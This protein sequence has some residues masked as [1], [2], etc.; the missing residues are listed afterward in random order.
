MT[1]RPVRRA[2]V[3]TPI[4]GSRVQATT[5]H[6]TLTVDEIAAMQPGMARLMDEVSRRYWVLYYAA[7]ARNWELA[8]YM[9]KESEKILKT[10]SL[11]RPKYREDLAS[12]VRDRLDPLED[13]IERKDWAAFE[14]AYRRGIADSDMYHDKYNKRFI[15]FRLPDHPPEWFDL[16]AR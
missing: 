6:G 2:M 15:R 10:A 1:E 7:K 4:P 16:G 9:L 8:G 11:V 13:A 3:E 12:F 14:A 5:K